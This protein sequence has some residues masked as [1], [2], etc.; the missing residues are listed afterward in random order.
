MTKID[1]TPTHR[2]PRS[3]RDDQEAREAQT[4]IDSPGIY[5]NPIGLPVQN[6]RTRDLQVRKSQVELPDR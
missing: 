4:G 1:P 6:A 5:F 2:K 3:V